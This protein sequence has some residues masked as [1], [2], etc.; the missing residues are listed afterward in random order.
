MGTKKKMQMKIGFIGAGSL[1]TILSIALTQKGYAVKAISSRSRSSANRLGKLMPD[2]TVFDKPQQV[3][4]AVNFVF[5]T[6]PVDAIS[7]VVSKISWCKGQTVIHCSGAYS[8]NAL[9]SAESQ[10]ANTGTLHPMQTFIDTKSGLN[11]LEGT[12]FGIEGHETL[13]ETLQT[14]T[15]DMGGTP[16]T[17]KAKDKALYHASGLMACGFVLALL[18]EATS[19]WE[20]LGLNTEQATQAL[21]PMALSTVKTANEKGFSAALS[22]PLARGDIG[23]IRYHLEGLHEQAPQALTLYCK[24][25]LATLQIAEEKGRV[26]KPQLQA[27]EHLLKNTL[28]GTMYTNTVKSET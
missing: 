13:L 10:G 16:V 28:D 24:L 20:T 23:T 4:D 22:G 11:N 8:R 19:L 25:A 26:Q 15:R 18:K 17:L 3:A 12:F 14:L 2:C 6:T 7:E 5:I 9:S 1:G 27:I 21:L